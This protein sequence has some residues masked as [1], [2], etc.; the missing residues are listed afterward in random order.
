MMAS[1]VLY[2]GVSLDAPEV[3]GSPCGSVVVFTRHS[4]A[5]NTVNE[6][7]LAVIPAGDN[8]VVLAVADGLGGLPSGNIAAGLVIESLVQR[9][10]GA[11]EGALREAILDAI[12]QANQEILS[13]GTGTATTLALVEIQGRLV[14]S[15]HVGD[16]GVLVTGQ[17]GRRKLQTVPHSPT[18]YA[19]EAGLIEEHEALAHGE[20]NLVS[21]VVGSHELRIE[22]GPLVRMSPRDTVLVAS[23]GLFD[24]FLSEEL[25]NHVRCGN[26]EAE[27]GILVAEA[28]SRMAGKPGAPV[29]GH[30]DD[31]SFIVFRPE[32]AGR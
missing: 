15:Y 11:G 18:G 4:P 29:S 3:H 14:R 5:K 7:A 30:P 13:L 19:Q 16:A 10:R 8:A 24:N 26:L 28:G 25:V 27:A 21:N 9:I 20:R 17:R 22:I 31:L 12:E 1:E 6:D 32:L 23:D 2:S